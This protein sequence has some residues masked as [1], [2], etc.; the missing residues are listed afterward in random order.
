M[1]AIEGGWYDISLDT[2]KKMI[3]E[4]EDGLRY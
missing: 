3:A 1:A 2:L 4:P